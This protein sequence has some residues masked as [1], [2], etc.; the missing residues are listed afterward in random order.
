MMSLRVSQ[1]NPTIDDEGFAT[2]DTIPQGAITNVS[3]E[4]IENRQLELL[5]NEL[6]GWYNRSIN[7][8]KKI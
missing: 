2:R 5:R 7:A 8:L 1:G 3:P 4:N 6:N